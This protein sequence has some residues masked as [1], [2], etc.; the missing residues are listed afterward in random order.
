MD[1]LF[2]G[3]KYYS[4]LGVLFS[5]KPIIIDLCT[6]YRFQL[7]DSFYIGPGIDVHANFENPDHIEFA[8]EGAAALK[9]LIGSF[10]APILSASYTQKDTEIDF[11]VEPW[12]PGSAYIYKLFPPYDENVITSE[13]YNSGLTA[14]MADISANWFF[15][16]NTGMHLSARYYHVY[17]SPQHLKEAGFRTVESLGYLATKAGL[18]FRF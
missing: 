6:A 15:S 8:S 9:P 1:I 14:A 18:V 17:K 4:K 5:L 3:G 13:Y 16:L 7:G 12:V 2:R 11:T 10:F